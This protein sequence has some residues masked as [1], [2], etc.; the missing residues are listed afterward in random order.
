MFL[1]LHFQ[2]W[3]LDIIQNEDTIMYIL[4][5]HSEINGFWKKIMVKNYV[6]T[7]YEHFT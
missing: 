2:S 4:H 3:Y 5:K 7:F 1:N 6:G